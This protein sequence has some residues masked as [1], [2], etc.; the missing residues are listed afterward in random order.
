MFRKQ[1]SFMLSLIISSSSS[2]YFK[3]DVYV[4]P[5]ISK[6]KGLWDV[7]ILAYDVSFK[8]TFMIYMALFNLVTYKY[9]LFF[10]T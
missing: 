7:G 1:S 3:I 6:L 9:K 2:T 5:L 4:E 8:K 10:P